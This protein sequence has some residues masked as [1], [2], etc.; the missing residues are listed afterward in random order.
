MPFTAES[1]R[2]ARAKRTANQLAAKTAAKTEIIPLVPKPA[3]PVVTQ[4]PVGFDWWHMPLGAAEVELARRRDEWERASSIIEQRRS[5][6]PRKMWKCA[7]CSTPIADGQW[8]F[9]DDSRRDPETG[10]VTPAVV[11]GITCYTK[12]FAE[13]PRLGPRR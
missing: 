12:Y 4:I 8:K 7:V 2:A 3:A 9:K 13:R 6:L 11:C 10:L 5:Q 1:A